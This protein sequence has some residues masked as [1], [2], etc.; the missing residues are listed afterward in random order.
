MDNDEKQCII[1]NEDVEIKDRLLPPKMN[2]IV[3]KAE[4]ILKEIVEIHIN[5]NNLKYVKDTKPMLLTLSNK[6][7]I[8][9]KCS[10]SPRRAL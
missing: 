7:I 5:N 2:S 9:S 10:I 4:P 8:S 6:I 3:A 1:C